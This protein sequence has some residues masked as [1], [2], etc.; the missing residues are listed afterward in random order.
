MKILKKLSIVLIALV[1][2]FFILNLVGPTNYKV[3]RSKTIDAPIEIVYEQIS[4]FNNWDAWSPWK[5]KDASATYTLDGEDGKVGTRYAWSGDPESTGEGS[6]TVNENRANKKFGYDLAF[7]A[8]WEMSSKG[9]FNFSEA[10]NKTTVNWVD[11]GDIPF[12]QRGMMLFMD[13]DGMMG[14]EFER[15]LE[16]IDS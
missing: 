7:T 5:E 3:E 14:P 4:L 15:G 8:P 16:K 9:Y 1:A 10:N 13:L 2:L 11:E 12:M 6:M